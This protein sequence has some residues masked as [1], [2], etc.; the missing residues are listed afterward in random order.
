MWEIGGVEINHSV[1]LAPIV[2]VCSCGTFEQTINV[3]DPY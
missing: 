3:Q 1:V 2:G